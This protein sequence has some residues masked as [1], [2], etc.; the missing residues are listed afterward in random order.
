MRE[1]TEPPHI[2]TMTKVADYREIDEILRSKDFRQGSHTESRPLFGGSLLLLDGPEHRER[3]RLENP[4]FDRAALM[5]YDH[6]AL[7]PVIEQVIDECR[8]L[9]DGDGRV[10]VDLVP[11][12]RTMLH[13]ISAATTGIDGVDT[14]ARTERFRFFVDRLGAAATVE[15]STED[16]DEVL[17]EGLRLRAEFVEEFFGPSEQR[18]KDLVVGF[19]AGRVD[20][21]DLPVD[22]L[23]LLHLHWDDDWDDELPL[24]EAT[25]FLVAATQ[26]TTHTLPHALLH[27]L[28]WMRDHPGDR[29]GASDPAFLRRVVDESLRLHQPAPTLL[30]YATSAVTLASGRHIA[31]GERVALLFTPANRDPGL[32][33][34]DADE[35]DPHRTTPPGIRPW[36]LTFGSGP[37]VCVGR[38]LVTGLA[39]RDGEQP[40]EG[41]M[42]RILRALLRTGVELDPDRPPVR[43]PSSTHDNYSSMPVVLTALRR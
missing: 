27:L 20:R 30:R 41:T 24:R 25:L 21:A 23:T 22:L 4:L 15:W 9:D 10:R 8:A 29:I 16:H 14:P 3:R 18:R 36:G 42:L 7:G 5:S 40:T 1:W 28:D 38:P 6:E 13:R 17:A 33:G 43:N 34:A 2:A 37:H 35:F 31:E 32:F 12:V 26:T 39:K 11:L 19:R